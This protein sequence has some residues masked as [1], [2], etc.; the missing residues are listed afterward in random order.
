MGGLGGGGWQRSWFALTLAAY[1]F[2]GERRLQLPVQAGKVGMLAR[3]VA[4]APTYSP[5]VLLAFARA[6][7]WLLQRPR[8]FYGLLARIGLLRISRGMTLKCAPSVP[9]PSARPRS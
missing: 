4:P 2:F 1:H 9:Q 7:R 3:L 5:A 8:T 6:L